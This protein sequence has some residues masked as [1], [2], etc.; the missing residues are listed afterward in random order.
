MALSKTLEL[1]IDRMRKFL[2]LLDIYLEILKGKVSHSRTKDWAKVLIEIIYAYFYSIIDDRED[3]TNMFRIWKIEYPDHAQEIE[4]VE[5]LVAPYKK[6][7]LLFRNNV[8]FHGS[9]E[10]KG[11]KV[12]MRIFEGVG[13]GTTLK[14]MFA[15]RNLSTHLLTLN[16]HD[17]TKSPSY[18]ECIVCIKN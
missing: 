10:V 15:V 6:F 8:G 3:S 9:T 11:K 7:F 2:V 13:G 14:L 1:H 16:E 5:A 18:T 12:G 4:R 17:K